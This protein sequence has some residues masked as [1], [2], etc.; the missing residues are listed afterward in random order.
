MKK[1]VNDD[2]DDDD[3]GF[4]G[5]VPRMCLMARTSPE[6]NLSTRSSS[7][8]WRSSDVM[9]ELFSLTSATVAREGTGKYR[10]RPKR[11][12]RR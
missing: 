1:K 4:S 9:P 5:S 7:V 10:R 12:R 11:G 6:S 8:F 3:A 2:D